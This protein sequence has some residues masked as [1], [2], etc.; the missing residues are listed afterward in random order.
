THPLAVFS[1]D[2]E[3]LGVALTRRFLAPSRALAFAHAHETTPLHG[4]LRSFRLF[5]VRSPV[6]ILRY[7]ATAI[8]LC[9]RAGRQSGVAEELA[10]GESALQE[11][12]DACGLAADLLQEL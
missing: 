4:L 3:P 12:A 6:V 1:P 10:A 7:F 5:G 9:A 8:R 2:T 11:F